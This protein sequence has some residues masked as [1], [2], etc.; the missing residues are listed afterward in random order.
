VLTTQEQLKYSRQ[1]M[2]NKI[3]EQGQI[4]LR[5]AKVL[6]V[7]VGGLGNPV[8]LYLAAAGVGTLYLADG[9]TIEIS[10][11][12]RQIQFSEQDI[13]QNK[14]EVAADKLNAQFPDSDIEAI[15]DMLDQELCDYYLPQVDLVVD[16]SDNIKTRYLVNQA[17]ITYKVPLVVGAATGF[18]GQQL[19]V[20]PRDNSSACYHCL[21]PASEKAPANNCQTLG[22]LGPVLAI[23]A[24]MQSLQAIKILTGNKA[25]INQLNLFDGLSNQWQQFT[26]KKQKNC[27]V[28]GEKV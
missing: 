16:C 15:D 23:V 28:C 20:D 3:G 25:Q 14:A 10:N 11:L 5:N 18:D 26:M 17:C 13:N 21:F 27:C 19:V 2:M 9:D 24:G 7:G 1:I 4:A 8:S 6:V 22:I 12:P